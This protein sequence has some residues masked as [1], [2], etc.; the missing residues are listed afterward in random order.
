M[1]V[2]AVLTLLATTAFAQFQ[3]V[4][5]SSLPE[6]DVQPPGSNSTYGELST[7]FVTEV[8]T[9]TE[10]TTYCPEPT[11]IITNGKTI[12]V[13]T[14]T[15]LTI[16]DCPCVVTTS[17]LKPEE[18]GTGSS[19]A[20]APVTEPK[21]TTSPTE[22]ISSSSHLISQTKTSS[23]VVQSFSNAA[24]KLAIGLPGILPILAVFM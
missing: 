14:A 13:T 5:S 4:S 6:T 10:F 21:S 20:T 18:S 24:E 8:Q 9:V 23:H 19:K 22:I 7:A 3:N 15:T 11:T 1:R 17:H 2:L 12:V 16:T